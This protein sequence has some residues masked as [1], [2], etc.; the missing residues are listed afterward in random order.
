MEKAR[1]AESG[2]I[3]KLA[4]QR[5]REREQ[6]ARARWDARVRDAKLGL[7]RVRR[8]FR[9][10]EI[11]SRF[12]GS[13]GAV[14]DGAIRLVA[15]AVGAIGEQA[16]RDLMETSSH[17]DGKRGR[18]HYFEETTLDRLQIVPDWSA[19][20]LTMRTY[21]SF[22]RSGFNGYEKQGGSSYRTYLIVRDTTTGECH[23]MRVPP[24]FGNADTQFFGK[25]NQQTEWG[26]RLGLR[27]ADQRRIHAA[28]AWTFDLKPEDYS[29]EKEA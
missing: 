28:V 20:L 17:F 23:I 24:K 27:T 3:L 15:A 12:T 19:V 9:R 14:A 22:G 21:K 2:R 11:Q 25:F 1:K 10:T 13:V 8:E 7:A 29:P 18:N 5:K 6:A 4:V 16:E 26:K